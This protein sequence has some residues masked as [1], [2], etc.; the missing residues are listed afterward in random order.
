MKKQKQQK[1]MQKR[2][3]TIQCRKL[4]KKKENDKITVYVQ[5]STCKAVLVAATMTASRA[6]VVR[7]I[8]FTF[9]DSRR[10]LSAREMY[11]ITGLQSLVP[12]E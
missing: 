11:K 2:K 10:K 8:W 1:V 4:K 6:S 3:K 5:C 12:I 9:S 7:G